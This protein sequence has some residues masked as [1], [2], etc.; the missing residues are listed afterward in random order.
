MKAY[1]F[2]A[3]WCQP[4]KALAKLLD[5]KNLNIPTYDVDNSEYNDLLAKYDIRSVPTIVIED[6]G[7]VEKYTG[8][9]LP[10][11]LVDRLKLANYTK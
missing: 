9:D 4:C 11:Q 8:T 6:N 1:R 2:T 3:T 10:T 7:T 5:S